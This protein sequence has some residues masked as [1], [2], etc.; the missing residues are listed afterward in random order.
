M[1]RR[2][3][4]GS[5]LKERIPSR[6]PINLGRE[7]ERKRS[8]GIKS[9]LE[10]LEEVFKDSWQT[11]NEGSLNNGMTPVIDAESRGTMEEDCDAIGVS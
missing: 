8:L 6:R 11:S 3:I 10:V 4:E 7:E 9:I 2:R 5:K 1:Y